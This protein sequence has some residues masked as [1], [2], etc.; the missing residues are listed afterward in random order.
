MPFWGIPNLISFLVNG[1]FIFLLGTLPSADLI[2]RNLP[3]LGL[4]GVG[5]TFFLFEEGQSDGNGRAFADFAGHIDTAAMQF[6]ATLD[7]Q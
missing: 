6:D 5:S 2:A 7:N 1:A 4:R 3:R